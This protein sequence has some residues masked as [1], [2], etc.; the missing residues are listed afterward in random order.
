MIQQV[1]E[2]LF[3]K[4]R[5]KKETKKKNGIVMHGDYYREKR[6]NDGEYCENFEMGMDRCKKKKK[7][8]IG[9]I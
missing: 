1:A 3:I 5:S 4:A 8:R 6:K 2:F 9:D 7:G